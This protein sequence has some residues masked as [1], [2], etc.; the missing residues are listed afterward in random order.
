MRRCVCKRNRQTEKVRKS[1]RKWMS[2]RQ[3][4]REGWLTSQDSITFCTFF[5][6][7]FLVFI[8]LVSREWEEIPSRVPVSFQVDLGSK[9]QCLLPIPHSK[10]RFISSSTKV[11]WYFWNTRQLQSLLDQLSLSCYSYTATS[12]DCF[13]DSRVDINVEDSTAWFLTRY[14]VL[15]AWWS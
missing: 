4:D 12:I 7:S 2:R 5:S 9:W 10:T 13:F 14:H 3:D 1:S 6:C 8:V 15:I 11:V